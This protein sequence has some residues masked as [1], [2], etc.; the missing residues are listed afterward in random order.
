[1]TIE[2]RSFSFTPTVAPEAR[3]AGVAGDKLAGH[4]IVYNR[5]SHDLGG[6]IERVAPGAL[7]RSLDAAAAGELNIHGLW[8]HDSSQPLGST[9]GG[10][11]KLTSDTEGLAFELDTTRFTPAQLDAARDGDLQMSFGF[12]VVKDSWVRRD[13]GVAERTLIDV[14]LFEVSPVISPA[15]P[16]TTAALRSL[17]AFKAE[18]ARCAP[19]TLDPAK[20]Y[21]DDEKPMGV[22]DDFVDS[23]F[24]G[25]SAT[26]LLTSVT[27]QNPN[28][29]KENVALNI[30]RSLML[31]AIEQHI[32]GLPAA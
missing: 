8:S 28:V 1:M 18:E 23:R 11:L 7:A 2:Y 19:I 25:Q 20:I 32:R 21:F 22:R 3:A 5:D 15:Y 24:T 31:K 17:E 10:K 4:A 29:A 27:A 30:K 13:D 26:T 14:D 9:R 6:F 16:D 12:R